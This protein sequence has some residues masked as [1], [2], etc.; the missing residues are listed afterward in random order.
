LSK[1]DHDRELAM[2]ARK[3]IRCQTGCLGQG[4]YNSK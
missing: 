4:E 1:T 3:G 2:I